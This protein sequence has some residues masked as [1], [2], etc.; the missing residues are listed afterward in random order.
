MDNDYHRAA[1]RLDR[2]KPLPD[3]CSASDYN[4]LALAYFAHIKL[5]LPF[6]C[7]T[8]DTAEYLLDLLHPEI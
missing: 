2:S 4:K 8:Q 6:T 3:S 5:H 1:K 7:T